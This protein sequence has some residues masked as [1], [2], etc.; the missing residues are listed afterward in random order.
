MK[1][2]L[3]RLTLFRAVPLLAVALML[4]GSTVA[5]AVPLVGLTTSNSL[6]FFDSDNPRVITDTKRIVGLQVGEHILGID[7]RPATKEL[8]GLS[9]TGRLYK[10]NLMTGAIAPAGSSPFAVALSGTAFGF[11]FNPTVDRI[12]AVSVAGQNLR[13]HPVTGV[14]VD[15]DANTAGVQPDGA[16]AYAAGGANAGQNPNVVA[17]AYTNSVAGA[18][19]TMLYNIDSTLDVLV[20]Q[21]PPNNGTLNVVGPLGVN[22]SDTA[23]FDIDGGSGT[24]FAALH[25][26]RS[27]GSRLYTID[28]TTGTATLVGP[29]GGRGAIRGLAVLPSQ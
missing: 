3:T 21:N 22:A 15:F 19:A 10:I 24:A 9:S 20:I 12:R 28:L 29:I 11:D 7:V 8:Y 1:G 13:L 4:T 25:T 14:V 27:R 17:A 26:G 5:R 16:L 6:V 2:K 18:T 23:G